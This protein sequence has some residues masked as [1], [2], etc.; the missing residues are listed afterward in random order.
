[1]RFY[2][3]VCD[4]RFTPNGKSGG[5]NQATAFS[6]Q[7]HFTH[8]IGCAQHEQEK[9]ARISTSDISGMNPVATGTLLVGVWSA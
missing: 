2:I 7:E 5:L 6:L 4:S 1:M 8:I 9:A 3:F